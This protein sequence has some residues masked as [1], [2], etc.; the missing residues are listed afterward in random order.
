LPRS[1]GPYIRPDT[2][3]RAIPGRQALA[4]ATPSRM[5]FLPASQDSGQCCAGAR[6]VFPAAATSGRRAGRQCLGQI[7]LAQR[8]SRPGLAAF[9]LW[10]F[11]FRTIAREDKPMA[12]GVLHPRTRHLK[13]FEKLTCS[14]QGPGPIA[15]DLEQVLGRDSERAMAGNIALLSQIGG[16]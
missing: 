10:T 2:G 8:A 13:K 3:F 16:C 4:P 9:A 11:L 1:D 12:T 14:R 7:S 5:R 6:D 15:L